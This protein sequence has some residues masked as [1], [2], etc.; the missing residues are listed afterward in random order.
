MCAA[1]RY[2]S[3]RMSTPW[4]LPGFFATPCTPLTPSLSRAPS[5][6]SLRIVSYR[7]V[8]VRRRDPRIPGRQCLLPGELRQVIMLS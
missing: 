2:C 6:F 5:N 1:P 3:F 7:S 8:H 4:T